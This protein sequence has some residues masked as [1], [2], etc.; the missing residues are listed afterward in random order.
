M[1]ISE[2]ATAS[3]CNL[4]TIRYYERV[5]LLPEVGRKSNGY[6]DYGPNEVRQL[7]FIVRGRTLGFSLQEIR[8][9]LSLSARSD[10]PC[11]QVEQIARQQLTSIR[12]RIDELQRVASIL[13]EVTQS[14]ASSSRRN[15][16]ILDA[17]QH[18]G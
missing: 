15:C 11:D 10:L 3:G 7:R 16:T 8:E 14:C 12:K 5:G 6:R 4:E 1:K 17:L 2:A 9:L 13:E 18:A